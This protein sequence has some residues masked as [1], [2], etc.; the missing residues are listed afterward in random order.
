MARAILVDGAVRRVL[1]NRVLK[2]LGDWS[3]F[4]YLYHFLLGYVVVL[5]LAHFGAVLPG[6]VVI[7]LQIALVVCLA[8]LSQRYF[9]GPIRRL[10]RFWVFDDSRREV[11][12][13]AAS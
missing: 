5:S 2:R 11:L 6:A 9:E 7:A 1:E 10:K 8:A 4:I 13:A 12:P 3:Y